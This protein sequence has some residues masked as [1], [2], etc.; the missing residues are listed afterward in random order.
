MPDLTSC[1]AVDLFVSSCTESCFLQWA[2]A[3]ALSWCHQPAEVP[4]RAA[5]SL[6]LHL[7]RG[8]LGEKQELVRSL[9]E[10]EDRAGGPRPWL[11]TESGLWGWVLPWA[12]CPLT[13]AP[14]AAPAGPRGSPEGPRI[15]PWPP[16]PPP[17]SRARSTATALFLP[18]P[19][20]MVRLSHWEHCCVSVLFK[21]SPRIKAFNMSVLGSLHF[22][23]PF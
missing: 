11:G 1:L 5:R 20:G 22:R 19:Q 12:G 14:A 9:G 17:A 10:H 6:A 3:A 23:S 21:E 16:R 8:R 18:C 7:G 2:G 4:A 13:Y 15:A